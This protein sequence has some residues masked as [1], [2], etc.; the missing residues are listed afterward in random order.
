MYDANEAP[1]M[2]QSYEEYKKSKSTTINHFY[3]KLFL[4]KDMMNTES[5]CKMAQSRH[6]YMVEFVEIF[7]KEWNGDL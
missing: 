2:H 4:L 5:G 3:E 6:N 1:L 7:K